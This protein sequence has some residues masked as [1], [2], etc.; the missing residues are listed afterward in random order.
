MTRGN[1]D[2]GTGWGTGW[3]NQS[4]GNQ[5]P[6]DMLAIQVAWETFLD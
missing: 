3:G 1:H 2:L 5:V 6:R 4:H